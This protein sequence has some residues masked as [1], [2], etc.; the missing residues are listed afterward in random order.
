MRR[1]IKTVK[2]GVASSTPPDLEAVISA[3]PFEPPPVDERP[4][5]AMMLRLVAMASM[6][7]SFATVKYVSAHGVSLVESVFFRQ[8]I[9][10]PIAF[11]WVVWLQGLPALRTNRIGAHASRTVMGLSGMMLNFAGYTMLPLAEA[12]TI[13]FTV[14]IIGTILGAIILRE[15]TG[16]HRWGAVIIGFLGVLVM[17]RPTSGHLPAWGL[18]AAFAGALVTACVSILLRQL[19]RT[20]GATVTVFWFTL[21]SL[22]PFAVLMPF[23]IR[24]HPPEIWALIALIGVTGGIAQLGITGA[25]RWAPVAVVLPMDYS[26]IL[27]A[28]AL[29]WLVW[30]D[31]PIATTWAGAILIAGS[32]LYIAWR[33]HARARQLKPLPT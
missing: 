19:G 20:E 22:P 29:G 3:N 24:T 18:T 21:L 7:I 14:P 32:G 15:P 10:L 31:W 16:L 8:L 26:G 12:T 6:A 1:T 25:L 13:G 4:L 23:F 2:G 30:G 33:E 28:T 5:F 11:A 27:W 17:L 9:T